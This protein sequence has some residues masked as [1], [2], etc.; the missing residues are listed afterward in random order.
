MALT[1][2]V[3]NHYVDYGALATAVAIASVSV[4]RIV[5]SPHN[6][7]LSE[8]I[9]LAHLFIQNT[10]S[11]TLPL[12]KQVLIYKRGFTEKLYY[13]YGFQDGFDD[14]DYVSEYSRRLAAYINADPE[15]ID[16][17]RTFRRTL[18]ENDFGDLCG[19]HLGDITAGTFV[20]ESYESVNEAVRAVGMAVIKDARRNGGDG[21][22]FVSCRD[23]GE[24]VVDN[25]EHGRELEELVQGLDEAIVTEYC[26]Q[27][28][29]LKELYPDAAN[30]LRIVTM[31]PED[32]PPF[33]AGAAQRIGTRASAPLDNFSKGGIA[34]E[35]DVETG[36][37][38]PAAKLTNENEVVRYHSHPDTNVR[39]TDMT[40]PQWQTIREQLL[41]MVTD[42]PGCKYVGWDLLVTEPGEFVI[43]EANARPDPD[44]L[45]IHTPLLSDT[46][47]REF[48]QRNGTPL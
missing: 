19:T 41:A 48:Y 5:P 39:I 40:V 12:S 27:A 25:S 28:D 45:Q 3:K 14:G 31:A 37:L 2:R 33:I 34:S 23:G 44:V 32:S 16:N 29:Y 13:L 20:S 36:V 35:I 22:H 42:L 30:T 46:N 1:R 17:K 47:V 43:L 15:R 18:A 4:E 26:E 9:R 6:R 38:S 7:Q 21:V 10:T 8:R 11:S 24:A